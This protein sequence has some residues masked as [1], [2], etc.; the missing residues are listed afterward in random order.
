MD[1][2]DE[3]NTITGTVD[4]VLFSNEEN[5]YAVFRL[6]TSDLEDTDTVTVT[7][8]LPM[9]CPGEDVVVSGEWTAH[10][11]YGRQFKAEYAERQMPTSAEVIFSFL[12]GGAIKGIGPS[13]ASLIVNKFGS[14][15][16][17]I[18]E[19][20]P[21]K[22]AEIKGISVSKAREFSEKFKKQMLLR[23]LMEYLCVNNV[24]AVV[25][26]RLYKYY[27]ENSMDI[28]G[29]NPY[30]IASPHIGGRFDEADRIAYGMGFSSDSPERICAAATFELKH[31]MGNGHC[32]IPAEALIQATAALIRIS[33]ERVSE[34]L[35]GM[36]SS[37][38]II[39]EER[40]IR[41]CYLP[42]LYYAETECAGKIAEM[43]LRPI[44]ELQPYENFFLSVLK[45]TASELT[46]EQRNF[47]RFA[48]D[49]QIVA[50]TG[51][52]GTG[53]TFS[54]SALLSMFDQMGLK[55]L[56]A[57]PTGR[58]AKRISE[59]TGRDAMT[60]HRMLGARYSD[61]GERVIFTK[62]SSDP[63]DCSA[64]I[65]D[66][67]SMIDIVLFSA[68]L[69]ALPEGA[70]LVLVG[71]VDQLP[72]VGAGYPFKAILD[73]GNV[74]TVKL[75]KIFRQSENSMIV[76]DAHMINNGQHP[77]FSKNTGDLFRL[78]RADPDSAVETICQLCA[79]RL[80][81]KMNI[82]KESIQVI[83]LSRKG[84]M[85]TINL[86]RELQKVLNPASPQKHEKPYGEVIFREGDR[87]MQIRND[88][89]IMWHDENYTASG[90]GMFNG[91]IGYIREIDT[92]NEVMTVDFDGKIAAY[93]FEMLSE[94]EHSWAI[95]VHKS[96][97][98]EFRAVVFSLSTQ[99]K[100]LMT[101]GILYTAVTRAKDLLILVGTDPDLYMMIDNT[102]K[103]NRFSY[104]KSRIREECHKR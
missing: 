31:N 14:E 69:D 1:R 23:R 89:D 52:P 77:D 103:S 95:T 96:Q 87:V 6:R 76:S 84:P 21:E 99:S 80:P 38:E 46:T 60:I 56:L 68:L 59:L 53:K 66:E 24:R 30:I 98:S 45:D 18:L 70:R 48:Y 49:S 55:T 94:L 42:E 65:L 34:C 97:G 47:L 72:P 17:H 83:S 71:D 92:A 25:A 19:D 20:A 26:L 4:A 3:I 33:Q 88:Y 78:K 100:M 57:A 28:L 75:E 13:T 104:L 8:C 41:A 43:A 39:C 73:S 7:G 51:G 63:L 62:N 85:G 32:F 90:V 27:G 91:D 36:I 102:K 67:C 5:G 101:R 74:K 58:A 22:L 50:L 9:I 35:E 29:M 64:V 12:S 86:N 40:N 44:T 81:K 2:E 11:T 16:L 82:P 54:L 37:G 93:G 15:S 10:Q 79:E 61:D